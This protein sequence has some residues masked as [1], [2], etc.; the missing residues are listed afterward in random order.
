[1]LFTTGDASHALLSWRE[2][3]ICR[4]CCTLSVPIVAASNDVYAHVAF[5]MAIIETTTFTGHM[6]C[7]R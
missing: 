5:A 4:D 1:M 3:T 6:K 7:C 2:P